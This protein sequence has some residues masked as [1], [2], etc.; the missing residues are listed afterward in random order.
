MQRFARIILVLLGLQFI[1]GM[2]ANFYVEIPKV[3][4]WIVFHHWGYVL[5]HALNG[6]LLLALAIVFMGQALRQ[7]R[8]V[9]PAA[10]GLA[11]I[12]LAFV[13]GE[14]FVANGNDIWSLVMAL[15]FL[16]AFASYLIASLAKT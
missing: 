1:L 6:V 13:A 3:Q 9:G 16:G 15:G 10:G 12:F 7:K 2:L 4:Y 14:I 8:L 11:S 5:T